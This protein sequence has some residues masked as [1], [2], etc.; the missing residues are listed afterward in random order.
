MVE[1]LLEVIIRGH[2]SVVRDLHNATIR[3]LAPGRGINVNKG[4]RYS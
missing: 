4:R 1:L 2:L 3:Q